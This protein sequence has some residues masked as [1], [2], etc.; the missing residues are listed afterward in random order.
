MRNLVLLIF[1]IQVPL[2]K[3]SLIAQSPESNFQKYQSSL[4]KIVVIDISTGEKS[5]HG[6]GFR[7]SN[8]G[9]IATN[10]HVVSDFLLEP[11]KYLINT[12][13]LNQKV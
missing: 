10:Y 4:Y 6:S 12:T 11:E 7:V 5:S 3:I 13:G 8:D 1:L 2:L 9:L